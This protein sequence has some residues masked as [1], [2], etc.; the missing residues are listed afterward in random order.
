VYEFIGDLD[1]DLF[2]HFKQKVDRPLVE[3]ITPEQILTF[4][5]LDK[6]LVDGA[7]GYRQEVNCTHYNDLP[8]KTRV[9]A[10]LNERNSY[11]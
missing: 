6:H 3:M 9:L 1:K 4:M 11:D 7:A 8:F 2:F 5:K 10:I